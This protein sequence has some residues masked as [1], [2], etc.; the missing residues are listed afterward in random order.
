[1]QEDKKKIDFIRYDIKTNKKID[2]NKTLAD[3]RHILN[4][5]EAENFVYIEG[6]TTCEYTLDEEITTKL[7]EIIRENK[8][9]LNKK[10]SI[11]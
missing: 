1:M 9:Y 8:V 2:I 3:I 7:K 10:I 11:K 5:N 4:L 6:N